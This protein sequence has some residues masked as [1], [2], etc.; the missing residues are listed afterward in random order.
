M[1]INVLKQ[2][3]EA[4]SIFIVCA[5]KNFFR[6]YN[7]SKNLGSEFYLLIRRLWSKTSGK[8]WKL[9]FRELPKRILH[10]EP[11]SEVKVSGDCSL[12]YYIVR[13]FRGSANYN[14][15]PNVHKKTFPCKRE[16]VFEKKK[17][18]ENKTEIF[19]SFS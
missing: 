11:N 1:R 13:F 3:K 12:R 8:I 5:K 15:S 4:K 10:S 9:N 7:R 19:K 14:S 2:M 17:K 16:L 18:S 6:N